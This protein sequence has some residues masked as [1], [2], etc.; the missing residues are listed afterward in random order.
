MTVGTQAIEPSI[1]EA[2]RGVY[3][4]CCRDKGISVVDMGLLHRARIEHGA[5]RVELLLTSGWCPFASRVLTDIEDAVRAIPGVESADVE[6]VWDEAWSPERLADS[7]RRKLQFLP[8]PAA[9][10]DPESYLIDN[11]PNP[12][13]PGGNR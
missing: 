5:A 2:L 4:P 12:N 3:D 13:N 10:A 6:I 9:V 8:A 7:A 1:A 11:W